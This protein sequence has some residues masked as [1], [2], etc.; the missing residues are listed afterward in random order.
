M[1]DTKP[2]CVRRDHEGFASSPEEP[3]PASEVPS[4]S[5]GEFFEESGS[6]PPVREKSCL[7]DEAGEEESHV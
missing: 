1:L 6:S 4:I 3:E 2:D 5:Q 7:S